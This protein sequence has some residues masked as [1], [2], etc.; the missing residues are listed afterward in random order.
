MRFAF[1]LPLFLLVTPPARAELRV[2]PAE[3]RLSGKAARQQL[4][5][6][7]LSGGRWVDRTNE[8]I[9]TVP[10]P[11]RV[12]VSA[13]GLL[14]P[15]SDG[16]CIVQIT[17][18]GQTTRMT[19]RVG[20]A[21]AFN[22]VSFERDVQPIMTR[23]GCNSGPCH[24]KARGQNGFALSLLGYDSDFDFASLTQDARGRRVF[25]AAP[26]S[27]V[28]L[29]KA[30]GQMPHGGGRRLSANE[31][32]HEALIRWVA[33]GM[34]RTP[35][36]QPTLERIT[37]DPPELSMGFRQD[38]RMLVTA[39]YSDG[40]REDVTHLSTFQ[41][42][43][44][45]YAGVDASGRIRTGPLPGEAAIM[46]R[47]ME[48]FAVC[49]V[50]I[51]QSRPVPEE[52]YAALP[53][54]NFIDGHVWNKLQ[55][56]GLK[57]AELADEATFHRRAFLDII[58]RLPTPAETRD[59]LADAS[60]TKKAALIDRLLERPEYADWWANKW[61]DLLRPN[62]Y[63]VGIKAV[64]NLDAWLRESFRENKPYD[65]FVRE[66]LT[67]RGSTFRNGAAVVFRNRREPDELTT[68]MSQLFLG[69]RL[70]CA[71]CHHHPFEI[72]GQNDFYSMAAYF[73]RLGHQGFGISAPISG[74]EETI[75]LSAGK[76][77]VRHPLTGKV[78]TPKPLTGTA[79]VKPDEDPR[80]VFARWVTSPENPTFAKV[81]VN[82]IWA[83][84]M[85]R[86]IV[87]PV[88]DLRAT[89]PPSNG[90]LLNALADD[91]RK[92]GHDLKKLM[93]T[94]AL[95]RV[96]SLGTA[97]N[98]T[99]SGDQRNYSRHYRQRLRAEVLLDAASDVTGV[100]ESF[101][102]MPPGSRAMEAWTVRM[103]SL[104]LDSFGR[105]DPNQDPPCERTPDTSVVQSLHLMN[106]PALHAKITHED[107]RA[108]KLAASKLTPAE[109]V[110]EL[111]L[112]AY[113]R[114]PS[115]T[116]RAKAVARFE[117]PGA[118]RRTVTEDLMWALLNTPEFVF[119]N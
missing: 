105:P 115:E 84:F 47:Y 96:Y 77:E 24:G 46:A 10:D 117:K 15:A 95:S 60:P 61:A 43:D 19:V 72:W 9:Y 110:A 41:S 99:N 63:H 8:A 54:N 53:R 107:G 116:E 37:I 34:P 20:H 109:I 6:Q 103:S 57:P 2:F 69:V 62:P 97:P 3:A 23:F 28:L 101:S 50:L 36:G 30:T 92:N 14:T 90:P 64:Y 51:P 11:K 40:T 118:V 82:R 7:E 114:Q 89:N 29:R 86:G 31:P 75:I 59:Y 65:V 104:F 52:F 85:G 108:A 71:K 33:G 26:E 38:H 111:Y 80:Q 78:M 35:A 42:N 39:F 17:L 100:P 70:D 91:F 18:G 102:G 93:R 98:D 67:A 83:D 4:L 76:G 73:G 25:P 79:E 5:V 87:D 16:D 66:L 113:S 45:V 119:N 94:I 12:V 106:S 49:N 88:D 32:A 56:L 55:R 81:I 112:S 68:M 27:S 1:F 44:S 48:K 74:G 21:S 22:V 58:G 13:G